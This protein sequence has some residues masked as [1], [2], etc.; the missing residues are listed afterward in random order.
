MSRSQNSIRPAQNSPRSVGLRIRSQGE[1][2]NECRGRVA[3]GG[4]SSGGSYGSYA[5]GTAHGTEAW[6]RYGSSKEMEL[7]TG[8]GAGT[9]VDSAWCT[10]I[11]RAVDGRLVRWVQEGLRWL[12]LAWPALPDSV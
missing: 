4:R 2:P 1:G 7:G 10:Q 8:A 9:G 12:A 5:T 11:S 3:L 6:W